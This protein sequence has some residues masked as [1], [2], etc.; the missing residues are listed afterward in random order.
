MLLAQLAVIFVGVAGDRG[1]QV[2]KQI[3][4]ILA[5]A[6]LKASAIPAEDLKTLTRH[7]GD[8]RQIVKGLHA[9]GVVGAEL[10]QSDG[11]WAFR[12]VIYD[13]NG[14]LKSLGET[15]LDGKSLSLDDLE[16]LRNNLDTELAG[17]PRSGGGRGN[18]DEPAPMPAAPARVATPMTTKTS[19]LKKKVAPPPQD[20]VA[21]DASHDDDDAPPG[22]GGKPAAKKPAAKIA[23]ATPKPAPAPVVEETGEGEHH[24]AA[25]TETADRV[26]MDDIE[27]MTAGGSA[28]GGSLTESAEGKGNEN[29]FETLH[30]HANVGLGVI[31]RNF[32][33]PASVDSYAT[34]PVGAVHFE[35]GV[36]PTERIHVTVAAERT[37]SMS[38]ELSAGMASTTVSRWQGDASY[39]LVHGKSFQLAADLGAGRRTFTIESADPSRTPDS[40]YNYVVLGATATAALGAK[41][42]L[43]GNLAIQ[44]VIGGAQE[45]FAM[46]FG[47]ATRW[48]FD[49]GAALDLRP[50]SHVFARVAVD[51]Q[52]FVWSWS[53]AGARATGGAVDSYPSG[54]VSLGAEY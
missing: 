13:K 43:H 17:M 39:D 38:T 12:V 20:E 31:G 45:Q 52:R 7:G 42:A 51:Y 28:A 4:P 15:P 27:S 49:A 32:V 22:L 54:M 19:P 41:V 44:P 5:H 21:L 35:A 29:A 2:Q 16:T 47:D 36:H 25:P 53:G 1:G 46:Q 33:G 10:V 18:N 40:N 6:K 34:S 9:D 8:S 26:S 37:L 30:L 48:A 24:D 11:R 14:S 3:A 23:K 50:F